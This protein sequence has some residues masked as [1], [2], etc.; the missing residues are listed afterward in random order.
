MIPSAVLLENVMGL[1]VLFA[2]AIGLI[3]VVVLAAAAVSVIL[4]SLSSG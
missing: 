4:S 1:G 2:G 3:V